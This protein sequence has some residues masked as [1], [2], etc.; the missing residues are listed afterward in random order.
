[1]SKTSYQKASTKQ[2]AADAPSMAVH[3]QQNDHHSSSDA[4]VSHVQSSV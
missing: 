4:L 1:M 3:A 2:L